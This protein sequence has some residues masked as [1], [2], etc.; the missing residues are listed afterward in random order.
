MEILKTNPPKG[1]A[2]CPQ[3]ALRRDTVAQSS[4][5]CQVCDGGSRK[6][7]GTD[8]SQTWQSALQIFLALCSLFFAGQT[9]VARD[10][11][12]LPP[13]QRIVSLN[14]L[15]DQW[16]MLLADERQVAA[17]TE[18][19]RSPSYSPLFEKTRRLHAI[20]GTA[21]EVLRCK[22]DLVIAAP[23]SARETVALLR[24][25]GV[26]VEFFDYPENFEGIA[27]QARQL[28]ELFGH[29]ERGEIYAKKM[30]ARLERIRTAKPAMP[31]RV[32]EFTQNGWTSGSGTMLDLLLREC[33]H[34]NVAAELGIKWLGQVPL[35]R[36]VLLKPDR[37][38]MPTNNHGAPSLT[39]AF[40]SGSFLRR[41]AGGSLSVNLPNG[42]LD[43]G[44]PF[45]IDAL[46]FL[47]KE[48][49]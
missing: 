21:E 10:S 12:K 14:L 37:L 45:T 18:L 47:Q 38:I 5:D 44:G 48:L 28:A 40:L 1:G 36:I 34:R 8:A 41:L 33:G 26:R 13:P 39:N 19:S 32:L 11:D 17:V 46:E 25:L 31:L 29:P 49:R 6:T 2:S 9:A 20:R 24:R 22:P 3:D 30:L 15:L 35:E 4:A 23:W 7:A 27:K 42:T 16:L 43:A